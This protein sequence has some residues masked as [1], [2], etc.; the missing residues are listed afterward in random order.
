MRTVLLVRR[1]L[2]LVVFH[3][4]LCHRKPYAVTARK[5]SCFVGTVEA[6]KQAVQLK[7]VHGCIS[8]F[9]RQYQRLHIYVWITN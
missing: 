3:D 4:R 8:V 7:L 1:D 6:V 2:T 9:N 5:F